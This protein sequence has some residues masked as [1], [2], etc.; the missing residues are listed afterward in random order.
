MDSS[1]LVYNLCF[2]DHQLVPLAQWYMFKIL[3][4]ALTLHGR[5]HRKKIMSLLFGVCSLFSLSGN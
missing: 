2:L 5:S 1:C 3:M 4:V